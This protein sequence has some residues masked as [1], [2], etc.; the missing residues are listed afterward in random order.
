MKLRQFQLYNY[1]SI[2]D[3]GPIEVRDRTALVGR[4]ESGKTNVLL[5]LKSLN[6]PDGMKALS[7]VKD[8]PRDRRKDEFSEDL[9]VVETLWDLSDEEKTELLSVLPRAK[10]V[11]QVSVGRYYKEDIRWIRFENL[12]R[13]V[14]DSDV[15]KTATTKIKQSVNGS[16]KAVDDPDHHKVVSEALNLLTANVLNVKVGARNWADNV[17]SAI[18]NFEATL[19]Q[20]KFVV[21]DLAAENIAT[22]KSQAEQIQKDVSSE[23]EARGWVVKRLA[24]FIYLHEYPELQGHQ[25]I[26]E[27][28]H[29]KQTNELS[30]ADENFSK[31]CKVAGLDPDEL[32]R[33]LKEDHETRQQLVN[34]AGA[35]VTRKLREL[36]TDRELTIRFNIDQD[37]FDTLVSDPSSYYPVEIN[38]NERS[39]GL[40]WFF[41]FY[42]TFAADT[43]GGPAEEAILLLD[44][45][46]L[47]LHAIAQRNL[48]DHFESDFKN[49]IIYTTHSPFMIPV[50]ELP[51]VRTLNISQDRGTTVTNDPTGDD[52]T[53]FP[54]QAA[55]GYD[56]TQSLFIGKNNLVVEGV[57]DYW[58]LSSMSDYLQEQGKTGLPT[59]LVVTPAGGAPKVS[60]MVT[61]LSSQKLNV[62]V[63]LDADQQGFRAGENIIKAKLIRDQNVVFVN[64]ALEAGATQEADIEDLLDADKYDQLVLRAYASEL[65]D[66]TLRLNADIPRIVKRYEQ[67]F[68]DLGLQFN[69]M[70]PAKIFLRS[71]VDEA[72]NIVSDHSIGV[73]QNLFEIISERHK[74]Q[75]ARRAGPYE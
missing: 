42:I 21:P 27:Y 71:I 33:L 37:H 3:S 44:E 73:F 2:N 59:D 5:A 10:E 31:L 52:R 70:R 30:E 25:N 1:R 65:K 6:P 48:L 53:L 12:P 29:R 49:T 43:T 7:Y 51:S 75:R 17:L 66:K 74:K 61:L 46:G 41:S 19:G 34:R 69:K 23:Q 8:F 72:E 39:R 36:W 18:K 57:S 55:L 14:P 13:L 16:L 26:P 54:I 35:V 40:K 38:L 22:I 60:Y 20:I 47:H 62:L 24:T 32:H 68:Q 58:Y 64:E 4:N 56:I 50:D 67:A 15:T 45:P 63:L 28:L 9:P 11:T